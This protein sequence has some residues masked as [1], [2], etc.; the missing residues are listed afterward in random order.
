M[1]K[2]NIHKQLKSLLKSKSSSIEEWFASEYSAVDTLFYASVDIRDS[3]SK[4]APVD[5]NIFP[6]GFNNITPNKYSDVSKQIDV[7]LAKYP[8]NSNVLII[9]ENHTRNE[10]YLKSI[11]SL[12][13]LI[14]ST[15]RQV[16]IG[17]LNKDLTKQNSRLITKQQFT[18]DIIILN[19]DL[20]ITIPA[21]LQNIEQPIIP[22]TKSGWHLREKSKH[23]AKY[24][25]VLSRFCKEFQLDKFFLS[26]AFS[27]CG[28]VNFQNSKGL[29]C[30][31]NDVEKML[32]LLK[33]K[34]K[35]YEIDEEPYIFIKAAKGTYGM[36]IMTVTSGE[37]VYAMN[38]KLRKKMH[39]IKEGALNTKVVIQEGIRT[40][41]R[42]KS[43]PQK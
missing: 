13:K 22:D 34:Y 2:Y 23:F 6:A 40:N 7:F 42:Y 25:E 26:T 32:H 16:V 27:N 43:C 20:T 37:E 5:T 1:V 33:G 38:R 15:N 21:I 18:P 17:D 29:D 3:G 19:N 31:A 28:K 14:E 35:E 10:F 9:P 11:K 24:D 4:I 39:V 36:G 41:I 30:I 8:K 12:Q